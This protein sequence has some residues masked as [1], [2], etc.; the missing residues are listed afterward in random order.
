MPNYQQS[1]IYKIES[2]LG[3]KIYIGATCKEYLSQRFQAHKSNYKCWKN[4][5][6]HR[7]TSF[8]V[9]DLYGIENCSIV[10]LEACPCNSKDE[11]NAKESHYIRT[12]ECV[13]KVIPDRSQ[14]EYED[15]EEGKAKRKAYRESIECKAKSKALYQKNKEAIRKAYFEKK[16]LATQDPILI[17]SNY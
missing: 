9:F 4:G 11:Q 8:D 12:M 5:K 13:N 6:Y 10:L 14:K 2:N 17:F 15:S 1:R 16:A 3:D 7:V